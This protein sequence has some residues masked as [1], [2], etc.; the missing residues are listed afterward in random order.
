MPLLQPSCV[1]RRAVL[2]LLIMYALGVCKQGLAVLSFI[3]QACGTILSD[4]QVGSS[5]AHPVFADLAAAIS[6][7]LDEDVQSSKTPFVSRMQQCFAVK[8]GRDS[9]LDLARANFCRISE[10]IHKLAAAC[11]EQFS[12]NLKVLLCLHDVQSSGM[13]WSC[14]ALIP[15]AG[16]LVE[17]QALAQCWF[18][19]DSDHSKDTSSSLLAW[20]CL[21]HGC[22]LSRAAAMCSAGDGIASRQLSSECCCPHVQLQ[23]AAKRGFYLSTPKPGTAT[24]QG[25]PEV[26]PLPKDFIQVDAMRSRSTVTCTTHKL[27][28]LNSRL[29]DASSDCLVL[30]EQVDNCNTAYTRHIKIAGQLQEEYLDLLLHAYPKMAGRCARCRCQRHE[31]SLYRL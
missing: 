6:A 31:H 26:P 13:A 9:F 15:C 11:S 4:M 28:A 21:I 2:V 16:L 17:R 27:N 19:S 12:L 3:L 29:S 14:Q 7:V 30:T 24:K 18:V 10:D 22:K 8:T 20:Q 1:M 5:A 23:Y 25:V